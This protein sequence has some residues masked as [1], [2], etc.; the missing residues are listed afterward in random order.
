VDNFRVDLTDM[1]DEIKGF[2]YNFPSSVPLSSETHSGADVGIFAKG[3][4]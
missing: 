1:E 4:W 3:M 2:E